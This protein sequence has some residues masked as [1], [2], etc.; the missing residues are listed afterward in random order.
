MTNRLMTLLGAAGLVAQLVI[1]S[2]CSSGGGATTGTGGSGTPSGTGGSSGGG[3]GGANAGGSSGACDKPNTAHPMGDQCV[4]VNNKAACVDA[5]DKPCWNTCGPNH[6]GVKNCNCVGG[7]WSC[8]ACEYDT[9]DPSKFACYKNAGSVACPPDPSDTSGMMLP[10]S[11]TACTQ[12]P[13]KPCGSGAANSYRDSSGAPKAGWCVCVP[14]TDGSGS[15]YSCASVK[16]WA[17]QCN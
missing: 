12:D 14:K 13:C 6:S 8:P 5:T 11:G 10:A 1:V 7:M 9:T 4:G 16:E 3:N 15:V 2:G 17:P